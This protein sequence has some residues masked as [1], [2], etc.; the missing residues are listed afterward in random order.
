VKIYDEL[1][2]ELFA[3]SMA[4]TND[5]G[6]IIAGFS[7]TTP[8]H[9]MLVLKL[10]C[11]GTIEWVKVFTDGF[12][13]QPI[14]IIQTKDGG[15]AI[16]GWT[17]SFGAGESDFIVVKLGH[18]GNLEW[19]KTYGGSYFEIA[20][21]IIQTTDGGYCIVGRTMSFGAGRNDIMVIKITST[22]V[23]EWVRTFGGADDENEVLLYKHQQEDMF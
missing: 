14:S 16:A 13:D 21:S 22:G 4:S 7:N 1:G 5:G 20:N 2:R 12:I 11:D 6:Y 15:Y 18:E 3:H 19:A 10:L 8:D 17:E 23:L 9:N